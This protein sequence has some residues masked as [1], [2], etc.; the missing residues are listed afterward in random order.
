LKKELKKIDASLHHDRQI[1][2]LIILISFLIRFD[3]GEGLPG[4]RFE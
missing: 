4:K 3:H 1:S 2:I